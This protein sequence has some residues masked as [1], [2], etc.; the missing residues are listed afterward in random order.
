MAQDLRTDPPA[1]ALARGPAK[2]QDI[3][4]TRR[5]L[6]DAE[7]VLARDRLAATRAR[8]RGD[9]DRPERPSLTNH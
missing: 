3:V 5:R 9:R 2:A 1:Q 6:K 4:A 7:T 8:D